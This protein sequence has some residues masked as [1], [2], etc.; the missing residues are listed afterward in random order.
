MAYGSC[1]FIAFCLLSPPLVRHSVP[2]NQEA[3]ILTLSC[4]LPTCQFQSCIISLADFH[5]TTQFYRKKILT[6]PIMINLIILFLTLNHQTPLAVLL[7]NTA[8]P[9]LGALDFTI[10]TWLNTLPSDSHLAYTPTCFKVL[11][12]ASSSP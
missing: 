11:A 5:G 1:L 8:A 12:Q 6:K 7:L 10:P 2:W 9:C 3:M 4:I